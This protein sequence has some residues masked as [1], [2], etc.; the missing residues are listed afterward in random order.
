MNRDALIRKLREIE[1]ETIACLEATS[2]DDP[3]GVARLR[4][5]FRERDR[6]LGQVLGLSEAEIKERELRD[7]QFVFI[8]SEGA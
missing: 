8:Q 7:D 2:F 5:L 1:K 6:A 4:E 3:V